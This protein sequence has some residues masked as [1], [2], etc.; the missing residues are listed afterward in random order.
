[1]PK[2]RTT[3]PPEPN[4]WSRVPSELYRTNV[5]PNLL[6]PAVRIFPSGWRAIANEKSEPV[7]LVTT[8]PPSPKPLSSPPPA[9]VSLAD[10]IGK[11]TADEQSR[12][13]IDRRHR[14]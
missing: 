10:S 11:M 14:I 13:A 4:V 6:V 1:G 3:Q 9:L 5:K 12:R 7:R 8:I 2:Y